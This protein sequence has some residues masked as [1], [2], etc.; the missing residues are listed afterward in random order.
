MNRD[1][2]I[3]KLNSSTVELIFYSKGRINLEQRKDL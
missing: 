1:K 3:Q 2:I